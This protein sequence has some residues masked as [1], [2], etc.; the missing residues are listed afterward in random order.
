[1]SRDFVS[2]V[3]RL[4]PL[5]LSETSR[6]PFQ[7]P[8]PQ[9]PPYR[10]P[11]SCALPILLPAKQ[12]PPNPSAPISP[13]SL[14]S[15]HRHYCCLFSFAPVSR[16]ILYHRNPSRLETSRASSP[17]RLSWLEIIIYFDFDRI[18]IRFI[19]DSSCS[20]LVLRYFRVDQRN[21]QFLHGGA[22]IGTGEMSVEISGGMHE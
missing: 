5:S 14:V 2:P 11:L 15:T 21:S 16:M 4:S 9:N 20:P 13:R 8:S 7:N 19:Y 22:W 3:S 12:T 6:F 1:M 17:Q 10:S 18:F